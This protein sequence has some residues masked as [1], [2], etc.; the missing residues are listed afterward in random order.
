MCVSGHLTN[1]KLVYRRLTKK[2]LDRLTDFYSDLQII[3][4]LIKRKFILL[5]PIIKLGYIIFLGR[6]SL[7]QIS[8]RSDVCK[9]IVCRPNV[10]WSSVC[11][12]NVLVQWI[13][14]PEGLLWQPTLV[15]SRKWESIPV[16]TPI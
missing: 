12:P 13:W 11:Q 1:R 8:L 3:E 9:L 16:T 2:S 10:F 5:L 14:A 6:K 7:G 4:P 15:R